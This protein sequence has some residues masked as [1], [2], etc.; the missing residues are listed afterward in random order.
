MICFLGS[1][2]GNFN[3]EQCDLFLSNVTSALE[4]GDYFLL[5]IDLQKPVDIIEAAYN[6]SQGVTAE[7]NLN[8]LSHLNSRFGGNFELNLFKHRAFYNQDSHQ[9]EMRL[10]CQRSHQVYFKELEL[11]INFTEGETILTEISRKFN[12]EQMGEYLKSKGLTPLQHWTD[13]KGWFG[14]MLCQL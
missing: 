1:T 4:E 5:G 14:L 13:S 2:L 9:I 7:F 6:D 11:S 8:M 10:I 3:Q 12:L